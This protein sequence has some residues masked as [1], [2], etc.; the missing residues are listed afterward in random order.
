MFLDPMRKFGNANNGG[1]GIAQPSAPAPLARTLLQSPAP[2]A[3]GS[4]L[5]IGPGNMTSSSGLQ[6]IHS[7]AEH[8]DS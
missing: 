6:G 2:M 4:Q 7:H 5:P 1:Y 3:S 8:T